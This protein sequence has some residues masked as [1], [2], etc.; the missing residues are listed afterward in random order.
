MQLLLRLHHPRVPLRLNRPKL[1]PLLHSLRLCPI[2]RKNRPPRCLF[3]S[4]PGPR[5]RVTGRI[6]LVLY[7]YVIGGRCSRPVDSLKV[8]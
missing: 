5:I 7:F 1:P 2:L 3:S 6:Q 8:G 4:R